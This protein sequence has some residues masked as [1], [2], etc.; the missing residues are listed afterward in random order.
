LPGHGIAEP[1]THEPMPLQLLCVIMEPEQVLP[2]LPVGY[3]HAP[4]P[5][6]PVAP[7]DPPVVHA[8][9]Q[10]LPLVPVVPQVPLVHSWALPQAVPSV[11][12]AWQVPPLTPSQ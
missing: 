5:L 3:W 6:Q 1:A 12:F 8:E 9:V 7:Q 2:Q 4:V 11:F 10:Q